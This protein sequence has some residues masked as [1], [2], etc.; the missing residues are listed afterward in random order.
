MRARGLLV[1]GL[2]TA[3]LALPAVA[4]AKGPIGAHIDGP[5]LAAPITLRGEGESGNGTRFGAL[6]DEAGFFPAA[7]EQTP[8]PMQAKPPAGDLGPRYVITW[9]V[10]GPSAEDRVEQEAYPFAKAGPVTYMAPGQRFMDTRT[11]GGWFPAP[12]SLRRRLVELGVPV[13][14][15]T[16]PATPTPAPAPAPKPA[17]AAPAPADGPDAATVAAVLVGLVA[18]AGA[19]TL[20]LLRRRPRM[21]ATR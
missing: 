2:V 20:V 17:P 3:L 5:G 4:W 15:R 7:F 13:A 11:S 10:P 12:D 9:L 14:E 18:L 6:V 19:A 1:T 21:P 16:G 8:N